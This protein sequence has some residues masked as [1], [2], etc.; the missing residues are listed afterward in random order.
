M[1]HEEIDHLSLMNEPP[2]FG[3]AS[4]SSIIASLVENE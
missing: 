4:I 2:V 1:V 3:S